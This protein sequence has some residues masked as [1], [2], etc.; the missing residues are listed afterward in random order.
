MIEKQ[1]GVKTKHAL[2]WLSNVEIV[3]N[4]RPPHADWG[5]AHAW[6]VHLANPLQ[7][8]NTRTRKELIIYDFLDCVP[9]KCF[10]DG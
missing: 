2:T 3:G 1:H 10:R 7:K 8:E 5:L 6:C 4:A 9:E